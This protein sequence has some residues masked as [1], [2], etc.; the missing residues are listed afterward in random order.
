MVETI[1]ETFYEKMLHKKSEN[2]VSVAFEIKN[3]ISNLGKIIEKENRMF[4]SGSGSALHLSFDVVKDIDGVSCIIFSF[5]I[6][7]EEKRLKINIRGYLR[8]ELKPERLFNE[9]YSEVLYPSVSLRVKD[10]I[11]RI[12]KEIEKKIESLS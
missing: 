10:E 5:D 4:G 11:K 1:E 12:G 8:T 2:F 9:Y 3:F 7:G 6:F